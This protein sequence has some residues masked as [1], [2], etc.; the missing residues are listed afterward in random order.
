[1]NN[2]QKVY[3]STGYFKNLNGT[4]MIKK[5]SSNGI[6]QLELSGGKF[7]QNIEANL[8]KLSKKYDLRIH[9][10][11]PPHNEGFVI[12]LASTN[13]NIL[14]K[15]IKHIISAINLAKKMK[16]KFYS[17]HAGF[18]IDPNLKYLGK[19][20]LKTKIT[21]RSTALK[22]F[23][24]SV[25]F[26]EKIAK[27]KG[28]QLF[29]ENNVITKKNIETFNTNPLLLTNPKEIVDFF[30]DMPKSVGL[31]LDV[32]HLKVSSL[33][34]GFSL[35]DSMEKLNKYITG[36]H[37]SDNNGL[38]DSNDSFSSKSWFFQYLKKNLNYYTIEVYNKSFKELKRQKKI[39]EYNLK[40]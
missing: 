10:Y 4:Q 7:S 22:R 15:S 23:K 17:F 18:R 40:N 25:I 6:F 19:E 32:G 1:M 31:L 24:K 28:I 21:K 16:S 14:N 9:N 36:Y 11:F 20:F 35:S 5:F 39:I 26:L 8:I 34:E 37:L 13:K 38:T 33:T 30:K 2:F 29:I 3:V 27:K 12:N